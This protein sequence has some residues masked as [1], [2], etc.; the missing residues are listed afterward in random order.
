MTSHWK[1]KNR[2]DKDFSQWPWH[3][4]ESKYL[5]QRNI[6]SNSFCS[7]IKDI[8]QNCSILFFCCIVSFPK[9][10][11]PFLVPSLW[12]PDVW[13]FEIHEIALE[14]DSKLYTSFDIKIICHCHSV[15][16]ST[17]IPFLFTS[18]NPVTCWALILLLCSHLVIREL[19]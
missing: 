10:K 12:A 7:L 13:P 2:Y 9:N 16:G 3:N 18:A 5:L 4:W 1:F 19:L 17:V 14:S 15:D 6:I 11:Q 8:D